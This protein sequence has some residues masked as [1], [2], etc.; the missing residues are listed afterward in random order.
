MDLSFALLEL[1]INSLD[2]G[3]TLVKIYL[4]TGRRAYLKVSDNGKG[5][6]ETALKRACD[7]GFSQKGSAGLGLYK[8]S[9]A[10]SE[11]GGSLKIHSKEGKG[12]SVVLRARQFE[13]GDLAA[14]LAVIVDDKSDV[15]FK[16]R[17]GL[18]RIKLDSRR[19]RSELCG[20]PLSDAR[21]KAIVKQYVNEN[22]K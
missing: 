11:C 20:I 8:T 22:L 15:V 13:T 9:K 17:I 19:A 7:R 5:M 4:K 1:A 16:A 14:S 21:A 6:D 18:K 10:A 2:A 3:A 12:T